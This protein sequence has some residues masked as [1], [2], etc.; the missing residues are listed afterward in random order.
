M[1]IA[2]VVL[3]GPQFG[4][5]AHGNGT[6]VAAIF[7]LVLYASILLHELGH[8]VVAKA[9]G[10]RVPT[11]ELHFMGGHTVIEDRSRNPGQEFLVAVIGPVISGLLGV[12][13]L[14]THQFFGG[15]AGTVLWST[16]I[17]NVFLA[18]FN[19][20]PS[21]PLDGGRI[22]RA[23]G[24][25]LGGSEL[26]GIRFAGYCGRATAVVLAIGTPIFLNFHDPYDYVRL[27]VLWVLAAYMWHASGISMR[28]DTRIARVAAL[29]ARE[30]LRD[31]PPPPDAVRIRVDLTGM[32]LLRALNENP[33]PVYALVDEA[34]TALGS[35]LSEDVDRAYTENT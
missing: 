19:L 1:A 15:I 9:F 11:V 10:F 17:I 28:Y 32:E 18:F 21:P 29:S 30:L 14:M 24:W 25:A 31:V 5:L 23:L 26:S 3:F 2:L 7:V 34:G 20:L 35:L 8:V 4:E 27:I 22:V 33:A 16:G 6:L 13:F 12:S